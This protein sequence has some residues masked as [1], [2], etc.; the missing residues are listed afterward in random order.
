[1]TSYESSLVARAIDAFRMGR[2][3]EW[4]PPPT[5]PTTERLEREEKRHFRF[6]P[7]TSADRATLANLSAPRE[8][9]LALARTRDLDR[10]EASMRAAELLLALAHLAT[11]ARAYA[12]TMHHAAVSYLEYQRGDYAAAQVRMQRSIDAT[13]RLAAHWGETDFIACR[14]VDLAHNLMRVEMRRG[15]LEAAMQRGARLLRHILE[16]RCHASSECPCPPTEPAMDATV[17]RILYDLVTGTASEILAPL[18]RGE[19]GALFRLLPTP[20]S[21]VPSPSPVASMWWTVKQAALGTEPEHFLRVAAP[22]LRAG[23]GRTPSLWYSVTLD[24]ARIYRA[25]DPGDELSAASELEA[26]LETGP[27]VPERLRFSRR[28]H[29]LACANPGV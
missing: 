16:V 3:V 1:M 20:S 12:E 7:L 15:S 29:A 6:G 26:E 18:D 2:T 21:Q 19:A 22:F 14:R 9:A 25:I 27:R 28:E 13:D 4:T 17:A 5:G 11:D 24:L 10:A 23:R 8:H